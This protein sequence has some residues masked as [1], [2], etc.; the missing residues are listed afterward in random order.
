[1]AVGFPAKTDFATG[2][3]LT[4]TNMNDITGTLNLLQSTLYPAGRNKIINGDFRYNQR[5]FTSTT[6]NATYGFDRFRLT[7]A[8]GTTTYSAQTFTLGAAPVAGYEATN[9]ARLVSTG[10]T[11]STARSV[12]SQ[13]IESVKTFAGQTVV[14]SF[15]A[16]AA[17]G[18]PSVAV[19]VQQ[20]FGSGGSP[21][22]NTE[23]AAG[24][25]AI[26]TSW[27]RYEF[28]AAVPSISGKTIGTDNQ[29]N[30]NIQLYTSAGSSFNGPSTSL[31]IQSA[32]IDLWGIQI[33]AASTGSTASPFQT[34]SG[35]IAGELAL[36]QRYYYRTSP[37][38]TGRSFGL[39]QAF[40]ATNSVVTINYPVT[41]RIRPTALEQSGTV[42]DYSVTDSSMTARV[43][44]AVPAFD[45]FTNTTQGAVNVTAT[46][47]VAGNASYLIS[48]GSAAYLGWSAE[49]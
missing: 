29:D 14:V 25:S 22:A 8:D 33:E 48:S 6:T 13:F 1:M 4:A 45:A 5:A 35:S 31:G 32:T 46:L 15:W 36:C 3:V 24:K 38:A 42:G 34:A 30:L 21:S 39:G 9:F 16:K 44:T 10:Q 26:T 41:M 23:T 40:L 20:Y 11:L 27:A 28:T 12:L 37:G 18:T 43:C 2:E 47:M 19:N 7:T 17:S 49:L